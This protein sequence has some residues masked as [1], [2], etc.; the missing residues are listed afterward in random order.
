MLLLL[1]LQQNVLAALFSHQHCSVSKRFACADAFVVHACR[2]GSATEPSSTA[3]EAFSEPT[4]PGVAASDC[5]DPVVVARR[6][7]AA[8]PR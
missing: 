6:K 3:V 4:S 1:M 2:V 8:P 5:N 7:C